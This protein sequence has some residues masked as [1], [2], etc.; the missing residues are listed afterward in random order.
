MND[1]TYTWDAQ[2]Y[3]TFEYG[4]ETVCSEDSR[5]EALQR[6]AEYRENQPEL[7]HRVRKVRAS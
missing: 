7:R 3:T 6:L 4:W 1:H 2:T 5:H